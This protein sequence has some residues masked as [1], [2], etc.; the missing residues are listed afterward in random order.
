MG[1]QL[2]GFVIFGVNSTKTVR[3]NKTNGRD[4]MNE[5]E[6]NKITVKHREKTSMRMAYVEDNVM[7]I[8]ISSAVPHCVPTLAFVGLRARIQIIQLYSPDRERRTCR[9]PILLFLNISM[10][11]IRTTKENIAV[12]VLHD[13]KFN[14]RSFTINI[15]Y[16]RRRWIE[17]VPL[18]A[19]ELNIFK[20]ANPSI[21]P[22]VA[23]AW[24]QA[25]ETKPLRKPLPFW[26]C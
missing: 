6:S 23:I 7:F 13:Y 3:S 14:L 2:D 26:E 1:C 11:N 5:N 4:L 18:D 20:L 19:A 22:N 25:R 10:G 24:K 12:S 9:I 16:T 17:E 21:I 8:A 15:H